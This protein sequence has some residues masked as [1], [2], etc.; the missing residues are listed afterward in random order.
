MK[1][2]G[3]AAFF[4]VLI[5]FSGT[6]LAG[7]WQVDH[8]HSEIR[9]EIQHIFST[10]SGRF[11]DFKGEL[12]FDPA[13]LDNSRFDFTVKV[14]SVN[15]FNNKRDTHLR[16]KDFFDADKYPVMRYQSSK[17]IRLKDNVYALEGLMSIKDVTKPLK[18]EFFH[19][20]PRQHPFD[21][22]SSVTGFTSGFS[23][24]RLDYHVGSGKFFDLGIVGNKVEVEISMEALKKK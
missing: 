9:F 16:S 21:K 19:Y 2:T 13:D 12:V 24:N 14:K 7:Q 17:I 3:I 15:T 4:L 8:D 1:K 23:L 22:K 20:G 11:S 5:L 18:M 10:V 6:G